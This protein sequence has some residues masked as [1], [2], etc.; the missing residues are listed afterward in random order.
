M[1]EFRSPIA[2]CA[3][4]SV[5]VVV[6][7]NVSALTEERRRLVSTLVGPNCSFEV[8]LVRKYF[9]LQMRGV[10]ILTIWVL[11][12]KI[13]RPDSALAVAQ[14]NNECNILAG[15]NISGILPLRIL[16]VD[17]LVMNIIILEQRRRVDIEKL[18]CKNLECARRVQL[19]C[20]RRKLPRGQ[21]I[22]R[23]D[24]VRI[25]WI[26]VVTNVIYKKTVGY[27][28][29]CNVRLKKRNCRLVFIVK[30][31]KSL[32]FTS[33]A[34]FAPIGTPAAVISLFVPSVSRRRL[35]DDDGVA[36]R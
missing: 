21:Q 22:Y 32:V 15:R 18:G 26:R 6:V 4:S 30:M 9:M 3:L 20:L 23:F 14:A 25:P 29:D 10:L 8:F 7:N 5:S 19:R 36:R 1:A 13:R 34:V 27:V 12:L 28:V 24:V 2:V 17:D 31:L 35:V 33:T 16:H 11:D